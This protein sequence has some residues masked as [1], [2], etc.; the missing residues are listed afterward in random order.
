[1]QVKAA[2]SFHTLSSL[3]SPVSPQRSLGR[4]DLRLLLTTTLQENDIR[5][6]G[7]QLSKILDNTFRLGD[8]DRDGRLN[9]QEYLAMVCLSSSSL[10]VWLAT[11]IS[12]AI[13]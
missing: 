11:R 3:T 1:M 4:D 2:L 13:H 5:L 6:D 7:H 8:L 12:F 10:G 9:W